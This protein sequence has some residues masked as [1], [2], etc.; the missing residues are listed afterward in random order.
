MYNCL[1]LENGRGNDYPSLNNFS[2]INQK[3]KIYSPL[4]Q[5]VSLRRSGTS[6]NL[7]NLD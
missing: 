7:L 5:L 6:Q 2:S 3:R 4:M 1:F